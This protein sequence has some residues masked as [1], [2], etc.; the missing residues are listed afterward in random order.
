MNS[1]VNCKWEMSCGY[2]SLA[3]LGKRTEFSSQTCPLGKK[4]NGET[5][6]QPK[7]SAALW[8]GCDP[9]DVL[10]FIETLMNRGHIQRFNS[11]S[12]WYLTPEGQVAA[13]TRTGKE[14]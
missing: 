10:G 1:C 6:F 3:M 12:D 4:E 11:N 14:G 8:D 5:F 7:D 9:D 13:L 2:S